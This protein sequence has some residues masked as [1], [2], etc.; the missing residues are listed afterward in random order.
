[1]P[2]TREYHT[3]HDAIV[4]MERDLRWLC[5]DYKQFRTQNQNSHDTILAQMDK[6]DVRLET[7]N[8]EIAMLKERSRWLKYVVF[9]A[10]T[11]GTG[12]GA[13]I[14]WLVGKAP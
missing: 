9:G 8:K 10:A 14:Q 6:I 12:I 7:H 3:D 1:M 4:G 2:E 5:E 11:G 13:L